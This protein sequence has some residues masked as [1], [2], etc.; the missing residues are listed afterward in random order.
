MKTIH[1]TLFIFLFSGSLAVAQKNDSV[2]VKPLIEKGSQGDL[3]LGK[4][5]KIKQLTVPPQSVGAT[6]SSVKTI[7][8][9]PARKKRIKKDKSTQ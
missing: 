8:P 1:S 6:D 5:I 7:P 4:E 9:Q 2:P 3:I